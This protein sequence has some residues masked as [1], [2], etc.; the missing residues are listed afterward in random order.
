MKEANFEAEKI[1]CD[2]AVFPLKNGIMSTRH[3]YSQPFVDIIP[4]LT[5]FLWNNGHI[6]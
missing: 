5:P 2:V 6:T 4:F 3:N 1:S